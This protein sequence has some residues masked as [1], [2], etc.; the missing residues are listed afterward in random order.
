MKPFSFYGVTS[1][2]AV[3][4]A[5]AL[6][7]LFVHRVA[8][9]EVTQLAERSNLALAQTALNLVKKDVAEL[10]DA[11]NSAKVVPAQV[12]R[13]PGGLDHAVNDL[14]RNP[15]VVRLKIYNRQ[16]VV[17]FS[18]KLDQI[19]QTQRHN[20][21]FDAVMKGKVVSGLALR[22]AVNPYDRHDEE[23]D[24]MQTYMPV[25]RSATEPI[26][27]VLEIYTDAGSVVRH[28]AR[29]QR[30]IFVGIALI[31]ALLYLT[32]LLAA[33]HE[34]NAADMQQR[35]FRA[36]LA[37]LESLSAQLLS[38]EEED[39]RTIALKLHEGLAQN[40]CGIKAR[41]EQAE[42]PS[43]QGEANG[44]GG[45]LI[46]ALQAA[47]EDVRSLA[48]T[49]RPASLD[50]LGLLA[51]VQGFCERYA[52]DHPDV[53]LDSRLDLREEDRKSTRL[54]SSHRL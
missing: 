40:L 18:T 31:L 4:L 23:L 29:A 2:A 1:L 48:S 53:G 52:R 30:A 47:I 19:G 21:A 43:P 6:V 51:A 14:M 12:P 24:L 49:L 37:T 15:A 8:I 54:N 13:L 36:R 38:A 11:T 22:N 42:R 50:Q 44:A 16:G 28:S 5:G 46:E 9:V 33:R 35:A 26:L 25:Q 10:L 3:L 7:F 41:L 27:G 17:V 32:L 45:P 39:K 20:H 34:V